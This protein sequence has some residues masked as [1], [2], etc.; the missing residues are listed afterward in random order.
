MKYVGRPMS[1][2]K[3]AIRL[4]S[5]HDVNRF[6][7]KVINMLNRDEIDATKAG[8]FG[9]LCNILIAGLREGE[10]EDRIAELEKVVEK[11]DKNDFR[12]SI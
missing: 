8:R 2:K 10:L 12:K 6:I 9:F 5:I 1:G 4:K 11:M 3:R 7:A